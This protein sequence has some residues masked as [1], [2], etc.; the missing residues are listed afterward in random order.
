MRT[1]TFVILLAAFALG[2]P[3]GNTDLPDLK[4]NHASGGVLRAEDPAESLRE[5]L[6]GESAAR[7]WRRHRDGGVM[8]QVAGEMS[9]GLDGPRRQPLVLAACECA[10]LA[11]RHVPSGEDRP[12]LAIEMAER[13]ARG[14]AEVVPGQV[15][16]AAYAA[17]AAADAA[18]TAAFD[19]DAA[20]IAATASAAEAAYDAASVAYA[21]RAAGRAARAAANAASLAGAYAAGNE[22]PVVLA[23]TLARCAD[24][25]RRHYPMPPSSSGSP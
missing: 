20:S 18:Y 1:A 6:L 24:I 13:W 8:L 3:R 4:P 7:A 25:V 19:A 5:A 22:P 16:A 12:R 17:R 9:G 11:L 15:K 23:A 21:G 10:R 14:E 2:A